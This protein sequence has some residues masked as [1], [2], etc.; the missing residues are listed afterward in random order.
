M[1]T[2][3][4]RKNRSGVVP[5]DV[6][7]VVGWSACSFAWGFKL[8]SFVVMAQMLCVDACEGWA[9]TFGTR[10]AHGDANIGTIYHITFKNALRRFRAIA[11]YGSVSFKMAGF[12]VTF[13]NITLGVC[14]YEPD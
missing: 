2:A 9:V 12:L 8:D 3:R 5:A 7:T 6:S 14:P 11:Q 4:R 1:R 13:P 10:Q